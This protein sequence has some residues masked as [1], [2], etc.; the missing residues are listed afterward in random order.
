MDLLEIVKSFAEIVPSLI[1]LPKEQRERKDAAMRAIV[2]AL[3]ETAIY[4]RDLGESSGRSRERENQ[5]AK[6]WSAAA[7]PMRHVDQELAER[8]DMKAEFWL[9]PERYDANKIKQLN[10]QL[11]NVRETYRSLIKPSTKHFSPR[12]LEKDA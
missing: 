4:Y 3:D 10:I 2:I 6:Y 5:L 9:N 7:I 8:C 12:R 11:D 1:L